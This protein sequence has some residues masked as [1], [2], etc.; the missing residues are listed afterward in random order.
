MA[1]LQK[2]WRSPEGVLT[3]LE[4]LEARRWL[5]EVYRD[6][7]FCLSLLVIGAFIVTAVV[8]VARL[9]ATFPM[10]GLVLA[11]VA[12]FLT[13][14][15]SFIAPGSLRRRDIETGILHP[16][17]A[18]GPAFNRWARARAA[19]VTIAV[20]AGLALV[21]L[22]VRSHLAL[23][24]VV[25]I[26]L[27]AGFAAVTTGFP[28]RRGLNLPPLQLPGALSRRMPMPPSVRMSLAGAFRRKVGAV[29]VSL[30][31]I[32]LWAFATPASALATHNNPGAHIGFAM[33]TGVGLIC[34]LALAWPNLRLVRFLAFQPILLRRIVARLCGPQVGLVAL[35]ALAAAF[36]GG[37]PLGLALVS[38]AVVVGGVCVWL[39]LLVPYAMTRTVGAAPMMAVSELI[40]AATV[41]FALQFGLVAVGWLIFR[42]IGNILAVGRNRWR[43]PL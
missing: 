9:A 41:K 31:N 35:L 15:A 2:Y 26:G 13:Y 28:L 17:V 11:V 38:A 24:C 23:P 8:N 32:G 16:W 43:E 20:C 3:R 27:G 19:L 5:R 21:V 40:V 33:I 36:G 30:L 22:V 4:G 42:A 39:V 34:G 12:G 29:P 14:R 37:Q 6:P 25:G 10:A 7:R 18:F 1:M